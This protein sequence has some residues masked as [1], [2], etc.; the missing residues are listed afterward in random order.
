ME[1]P[2]DYLVLA[3]CD[4]VKGKSINHGCETEGKVKQK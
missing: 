3:E 2:E 4:G 1:L